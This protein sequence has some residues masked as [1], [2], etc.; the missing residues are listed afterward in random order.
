M[1]EISKKPNII[2]IVMDA[3]RPDH[4]SCYGYPRGTSPNIDKIAKNGALFEN[5]FSAAEWSPPSHASIFTGKYPSHHKTLG[6]N[7]FFGKEN[8]ALADVL[9]RNGYLTAGISGNNIISPEF[10]FDRGFQKYVTMDASYKS[11]K[12]IMRDPKDFVRTLIYGPDRFT[13]RINE[14][15]KRFLHKHSRSSKPFFL[16]VNFFNCHAPYDPPRPFKKR[17]CNYFKEPDFFLTQFLSNK[18]FGDTREKI[19]NFEFDMRKL[20]YIASDDGQFSFIGKEL[21]VSLGE[22]EIV[23]S[24]Y[25]GEISY[26]DY[27]VGELIDFLI[28]SLLNLKEQPEGVQGKSLHPFDNMEVRDFVCAECG[29]SVTNINKGLFALHPHRPK[30]REYD[31][32]FK[33]LR[34]KSHKYIISSDKTE[35][36]YDIKK[37]PLEKENVA[38]LYPEKLEHFRIQ[39]QKTVDISYFGPKQIPAEEERKAVERLKALGYM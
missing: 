23:K 34:T 20:N 6:R 35:E 12:F 4:L 3:V 14:T 7:V 32:G 31:K 9:S 37:D 27:R 39:L 8:V 18:I 17:F 15:I 1:N 19:T 16:F 2:L 26:L 28:L 38:S 13:Y 30:L 22:W 5:A 25:D 11:Y 21:E 36:L 33:C 24:W 29:E 10:R